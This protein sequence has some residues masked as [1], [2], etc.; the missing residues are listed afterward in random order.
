MR[1]T[2][3]SDV[4][5]IILNAI[6]FRAAPFGIWGIDKDGI[7]GLLGSPAPRESPVPIPQQDGSYWPSRLTTDHRV[8]TVRGYLRLHSTIEAAEARDRINDLMCRPLRLTVEQPTRAWHLDCYISAD[9]APIMKHREQAFTF[10]LIL[11]CPD[12]LKYGTPIT[13]AAA[14]NMARVENTGKIATYPRI[15][16]NGSLTALALSY[17]P[18][19]ARW[20]GNA[21]SLDLNLRDMIPSSGTASGQS[22]KIAPGP[23]VVGV[24]VSGS[25]QVT[26]I[27]TPAWR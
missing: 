13:F 18:R 4:D 27:V 1:V 21:T 22:F 7:D 5:T 23:S 20:T 17:G 9:A 25:A 10:T 2:V 14:N 16:A 12:P 19:I 26:V 6:P 11:T 3:Q 15:H 24:T 8:V